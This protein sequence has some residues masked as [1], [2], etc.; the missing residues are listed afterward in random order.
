MKLIHTL[1]A[2]IVSVSG[3]AFAADKHDHGH[4]EKPVYGGLVAEVKDVTYEFVAKSD[5]LQLYLRNHGTP[6]EAGKTTAKVTLL[7]GA[8]QQDVQL[9]P[10][11][12]RLEASGR[13]KVGAGTKAVILV[14]MLGKP[15]ATVRF[16]IK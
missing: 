14:S 13:F 5:K 7:A 12:D 9:T 16:A 11:G 8:E 2:V 10:V 4:E 1:I 15:S 3:S 6:V